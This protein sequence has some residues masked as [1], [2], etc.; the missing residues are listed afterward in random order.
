MGTREA[1]QR[2]RS[3]SK[4]L[5]KYEGEVVIREEE[6]EGNTFCKGNQVSRLGGIK[7]SLGIELE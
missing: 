5:F 4:W 2:Q 6:E 1:E 3:Y 7:K